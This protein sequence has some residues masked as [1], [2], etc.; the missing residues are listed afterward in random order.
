MCATRTRTATALSS[1]TSR[2]ATSAHYRQLVLDVAESVAEA[3][4]GVSQQENTA[5]ERVRAALD[6]A[7]QD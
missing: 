6:A 1:A 7:G 5:L 4:K 3:A 2:Q